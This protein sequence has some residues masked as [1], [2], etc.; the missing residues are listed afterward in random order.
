MKGSAV[1]NA[2]RASVIAAAVARALRMYRRDVRPSESRRALGRAYRLVA[3]IGLAMVVGLSTARAGVRP[4]PATQVAVGSSHVVV[5]DEG[6]SVWTWGGN[7]LGQL[8]IRGVTSLP[9]PVQIPGLS[10]VVE[11]VAGS[12]SS[13]ALTR[14]GTVY[15]WGRLTGGLHVET[16]T[17]IP[18]LAGASGIAVGGHH[19]LAVLS[20]GTVMALGSNTFGQLG[21]GTRVDSDVPLQ[22][23]GL[24]QVTKV[25][26]GPST[27][28]AVRLD[29]SA[30]AW[31]FNG[32][33]ELG[34]GSTN[35]ALAP[36]QVSGL[37]GVVGIDG[38]QSFALAVL[39]DGTAWGWGRNVDGQL[40]IGSTTSSLVPVAI[41]DLVGVGSVVAGYSQSFAILRD[42]SLRAW[43]EDRNGE[44][45]HDAETADV[46][47]PTSVAGVARARSVDGRDQ[48]SCAIDENGSPWSWGTND[49][50]ALGIGFIAAA[51]S[52]GEVPG[53][54][55]VVAAAATAGHALALARGSVWA[56]GSNDSGEL[57]NGTTER[58]SRPTRMAGLPTVEGIATGGGAPTY[59]FSLAALAD[60]RVMAWGRNDFGQLGDGGT[61][62]SPT[63][64]VVPGLAG[65]T[66]VAAGWHHSLALLADGAIWSWGRNEYGELGRAAGP[67]SV[68]GAILLPGPARH[69]VAA[70]QHSLAVLVDGSAWAWGFNGSGQLGDGTTTASAVPVQVVGLSGVRQVATMQSHSLAVLDDGTVWAWGNNAYGQL[71][72]GTT[73]D[74][75]VPVQVVGISGAVG[76]AGRLLASTA[77][78]ADG[79]VVAW[80]WN[81]CL[82]FGAATPGSSRTP[83]A[84]PGLTGITQIVGAELSTLAIWQDDVLL[85]WGCN[86]A[87]QLGR[88]ERPPVVVPV[89]V[90][91]GCALDSDDDA[92]P[93]IWETS[94]IDINGDTVPDLDLAAL[95]ARPD[96]KD[97]FVEVDAMVGRTPA[98][99]ALE[100]VRAAFAAVPA[101]LAR[102][103]DGSAG[104]AL[105]LLVD[106]VDL[107]FQ[108]WGEDAWSDFD[109]VRASRF[110]TPAER[111]SPNW[112]GIEEAK[113]SVFRYA[114]FADSYL[115][116]DGTRTRS[117][118]AEVP[119]DDLFVTLGAWPVP[120]GTV[121]QQAGTLMHE[122]GH[123]LGLLHRGDTDSSY[124]P[125]YHSVMNFTWQVPVPGYET[126]WVLDYSQS[127]LAPLDE[128]ALDE[129]TGIGGHAGHWVPAGPLAGLAGR[130]VPESGPI[131]WNEDGD[132]MDSGVVVDVDNVDAGRPP[133]PNLVVTGFED[134][135][136]LQ[137]QMCGGVNFSTG[138]HPG[139]TIDHELPLS[140]VLR[141]ATIATDCDGNGIADAQDLAAGTL[142]DCDANGLP[143]QC[144]LAGGLA[145]DC[146]CNAAI[147]SCELAAGTAIDLDGNGIIDACEPP[148]G[149]PGAPDL[150]V[151]AR[152]GGVDLSWTGAGEA[153]DV[154]QGSILRLISTR[155]DFI[156]ATES[157]P[158]IDLT[159]RNLA[160]SGATPDAF[161]VVRASA[162]AG[163]GSWNDDSLMRRISRDPGLLAACP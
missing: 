144:Q 38:G 88:P 92:L 25:A 30:W 84:V 125:N 131:D 130:L 16:P 40:G 59:G 75:R 107:P 28:Y 19:V 83:I 1:S 58:R 152:P 49:D 141:L 139:T 106:E 132:T 87:G 81:N 44:V 137:F 35:I 64:I 109:A 150:R 80:G 70:G 147:D 159:A 96:H 138:R 68:P 32:A 45:G 62:D 53:L 122:L 105:H 21:D 79:R 110:G 42:G 119:G 123:L 69:V 115:G 118:A 60:G 51:E 90:A 148:S 50:G 151:V 12:E 74:S 10:N 73:T 3:T 39:A 113:A 31:G 112:F 11:I 76:V 52:A 9:R 36:V 89:Q 63:P 46:L 66:D 135:T 103:P 104:I 153:F 101:S 57:G 72:D 157:C 100:A 24:S 93:D 127:V 78:L 126:S 5:L 77:L 13:L 85:A 102:N 129:P 121:E 27:S 124:A 117:G 94:A 134:W 33:G 23:M 128:K 140:R 142:T 99:A 29:G 97:L 4:C 160:W 55:G 163:A 120:G 114:V 162:C 111:A 108:A 34:D 48:V 133:S 26:G 67:P 41:T 43:G 136:A 71:G 98:P 37:S 86:D 20:N 61:V 22:V 15:F 82:H 6:G 149:I 14:D 17:A 158:G 56:W 18:P 47:R 143:D 156:Q 2:P 161:F 154:A 155:G 145:A 7:S 91:C 54:T 146:D 8:G 65:A 116:Q 95:G